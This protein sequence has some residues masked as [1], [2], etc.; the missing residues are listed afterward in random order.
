[1]VSAKRRYASSL[2]SGSLDDWEVSEVH[3]PIC[4]GSQPGWESTPI[5][6]GLGSNVWC[7][8]SKGTRLV[9]TGLWPIFKLRAAD[10]KFVDSQ[11]WTLD[12][13]G[14]ASGVVS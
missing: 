8:N 9:D 1:M 13:A 5:D 7:M 2:A 11:V 10:R 6:G 3:T 12:R 4:I 14:I